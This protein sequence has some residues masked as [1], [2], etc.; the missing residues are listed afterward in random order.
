MYTLCMPIEAVAAPTLSSPPASSTAVPAPGRSWWLEEALA[1]EASPTEARPLRGSTRADVAIVGGGLTGLWTALALHERDPELDIVLLEADICG[2]GPSGRNGGFLHGYWSQLAHLRKLFGDEGALAIARAGALTV[3]AVETISKKHGADVW[4]RKAGMLKVSAAPAQDRSLEA[5]VRAAREL[6]VPGQAK[7]LTRGEVAR[8]CR[9]PRFR[10]GVF[11]QDVATV[12]PARLVR[13]LRRAALA[14][15]VRIHE[16]SR[17]SRLR[18]NEHVAE[19]EEGEVLARAVVLATNAAT[20]RFR[21]LGRHLTTFGSSVVLTEPV[22]DL[23]DEVGWTGGEGI[24]DGRMFVHYFRTTHDGRVLMGSGS[25]PMGFGTRL[26]GRFE[27]DAP[28]VER[29]AAGLRRL[30]PELAD[31]RI[32]R[33]WGGPV[34]VSADHTPFFGPLGGHR[35][36][37]GVGYSGHGVG[38]AWIGGQI[39]A[40]LVLRSDDEWTRL[41]LVRRRVP[42]LPPEPIRFLGGSVVRAAILACERAEEDDRTP[43]IYARAGAALPRLF[44]LRVGTRVRE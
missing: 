23:L 3:P 25:G 33:A 36:Y 27:N 19:T 44:G 32:E 1:S 17:M 31:A 6:G 15:G 7:P 24:V 22:P 12:Q 28:S 13:L 37:Y 4:L 43:G 26:D 34:D 42:R 39:L 9:S 2:G 11:F 21:P 18:L 14:D 30:L 10:E 38:P 40:S 16:R 35:I 41:P 20:S 29:A 5:P 8:I